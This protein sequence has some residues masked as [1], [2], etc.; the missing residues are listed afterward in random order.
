MRIVTAEDLE[1]HGWICEG[2]DCNRPFEPG[3]HA[4]GVVVGVFESGDMIES[5]WRC[6]TCW[7]LDNAVTEPA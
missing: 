1:P 2:V 7:T 4:Y 3:D 5:D 6:L